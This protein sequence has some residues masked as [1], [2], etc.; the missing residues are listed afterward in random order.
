MRNKTTM[1]PERQLDRTLGYVLDDPP[2]CRLTGGDEMYDHL[3]MGIILRPLRLFNAG[4]LFVFCYDNG[5]GERWKVTGVSSKGYQVRGYYIQFQS[6]TGTY[7]YGYIK[8]TAPHHLAAFNKCKRT[9]DGEEDPKEYAM[10]S[11]PQLSRPITKNAAVLEASGQPVRFLD[12][13]NAWPVDPAI[14]RSVV[15]TLR[16]EAAVCR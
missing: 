8:R 9:W 14:Q 4:D 7:S 2:G 10:S 11:L 1:P 13:L 16:A 15:G 3:L 5:Q 12:V 6:W